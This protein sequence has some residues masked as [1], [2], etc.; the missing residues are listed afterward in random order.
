MEIERVILKV[1]GGEVK[2]GMIFGVMEGFERR[3]LF[4]LGSVD[5]F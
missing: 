3:F 5:G 2:R 4:M 1:F